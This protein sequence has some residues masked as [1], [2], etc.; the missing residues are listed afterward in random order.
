MPE[1]PDHAA[2][3]WLEQRRAIAASV[4][5]ALIV[6][7]FLDPILSFFARLTLKVAAVAFHSYADR[8]YAEVATAEPNFGFMFLGGVSGFFLAF[9]LHEL[10]DYIQRFRTRPEPRPNRRRL[11]FLRPLMILL[12]TLLPFAASVDSYIR[13]KSVSTF[14]QRLA[15]LTPHLSDQQRKEFVARF[16]S[17]RRRADFESIMRDLDAIAS[18]KKVSLPE[19][20]LYPF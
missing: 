19:N 16:A 1:R 4:I 13:L 6:L 11:R 9:G 17:M 18:Q 10:V 14:N 5:A 15:V 3:N 2:A 20:K 12:L 7:Y 8:I